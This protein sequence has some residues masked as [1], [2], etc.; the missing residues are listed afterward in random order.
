LQALARGA[1]SRAD[2]VGGLHTK[3]LVKA[4]V[5]AGA[6][7][8][9]LAWPIGAEARTLWICTVDGTPET[10]VSAGD[11]AFNGLT[12]ANSRAGMVFEDKFGEENCHVVRG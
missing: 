9:L 8:V 7:T 11:D 3:R 12:K 5:A 2:R 1:W 10:F 4:A 6:L